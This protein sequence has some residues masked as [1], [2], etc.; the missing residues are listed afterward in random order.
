ME[1]TATLLTCLQGNILEL[2]RSY[3][4]ITFWGL[5]SEAY[6]KFH[7]IKGVTEKVSWGAFEIDSPLIIPICEPVEFKYSSP[8]KK[9]KLIFINSSQINPL[10]PRIDFKRWN[11]SLWDPKIIHQTVNENTETYHI[12]GVT[13]I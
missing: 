3:K 12:E 2:Q 7:L 4:L 11:F 1:I 13:I 9:A 10:T 6:F 5:K 8:I